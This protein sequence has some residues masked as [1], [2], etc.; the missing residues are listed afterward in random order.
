METHYCYLW[1]V[2]LSQSSSCSGSESLETATP[3][4]LVFFRRVC[5]KR[6]RGVLDGVRLEA[7]AKGLE[8]GVSDEWERRSSA[9][10]S[11][12]LELPIMLCMPSHRT[13]YGF[14]FAARSL[15]H[16]PKATSL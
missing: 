5:E 15:K 8:W 14:G 6:R 12:L 7:G 13:L 10:L 16:L 2:Y 4:Q 9:P 11:P 1:A 3:L